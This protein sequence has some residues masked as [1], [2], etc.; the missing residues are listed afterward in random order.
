VQDYQA[1]GYVE[2]LLFNDVAQRGRSRYMKAMGLSC[3]AF[4][5]EPGSLEARDLTITITCEK[6][7]VPFVDGVPWLYYNREGDRL[8]LKAVPFQPQQIRLLQL[9]RCGRDL[10][11]VN[12]SAVKVSHTAINLDGKTLWLKL[13]E[14]KA[15]SITVDCA[16]WGEPK[17]LVG[18]KRIRYDATSHLLEISTD[19]KVQYLTVAWQ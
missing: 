13:G 2:M 5:Y 9:V 18:G 7:A 17:N 19:E 10:P 15:G 12:T 6:D 14:Q 11:H 4:T 16:D 1:N 3:E 8:T